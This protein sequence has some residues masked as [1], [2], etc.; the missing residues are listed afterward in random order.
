MAKV[1]KLR[2]VSTLLKEWR[3][4]L[5]PSK[6]MPHQGKQEMERRCSQRDY[7]RM[8]DGLKLGDHCEE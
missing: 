8:M 5:K 1:R 3:K 6:Y 4:I 2:G 7:K